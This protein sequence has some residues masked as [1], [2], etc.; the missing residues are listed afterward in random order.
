M[1]GLQATAS[2]LDESLFIVAREIIATELKLNEMIVLQGQV[3]H[4][5]FRAPHDPR[6][7]QKLSQIDR[8][9]DEIHEALY[10]LLQ[11]LTSRPA[12]TLGGLQIKAA[13]A[14]HYD[15]VSTSLCVDI[16]GFE[17]LEG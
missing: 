11:S 5:M 16:L 15:D 6:Y 3:E 13:F 8:S 14:Q 12:T 9:L 17:K 1:S 10:R 4:A 2:S 7:E